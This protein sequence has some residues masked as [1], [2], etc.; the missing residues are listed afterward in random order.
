MER[1]E[2]NRWVEGR[3]GGTVRAVEVVLAAVVDYA[4][5]SGTVAYLRLYLASMLSR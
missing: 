1:D 3:D 2:R 5:A 4:L